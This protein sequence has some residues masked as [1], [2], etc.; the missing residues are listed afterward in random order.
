M[1]ITATNK[2]FYILKLYILKYLNIMIIMIIIIIIL[3]III[4]ILCS[5][6]ANTFILD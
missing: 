4:I 6:Y 1:F 2:I 3:I 5:T